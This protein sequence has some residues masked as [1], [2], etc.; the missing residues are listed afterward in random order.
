M[1]PEKRELRAAIG[2]QTN[3]ALP[4]TAP[5]KFDSHAVT[6]TPGLGFGDEL[7]DPDGDAV[8]LGDGEGATPVIITLATVE[9]VPTRSTRST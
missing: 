9:A 8:G 1:A 6:S 2:P 7:G 3:P 5:I 4:E